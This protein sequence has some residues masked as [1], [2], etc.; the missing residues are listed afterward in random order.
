M[1]A[2]HRGESVLNSL[3][4]Y[5][6]N[7][8]GRNGSRLPISVQMV[9]EVDSEFGG[10]P[11]G[12]AKYSADE[13]HWMGYIYRYWCGLT[14]ETSKAVYKTVPARELR[15]FYPAYHTLDPEQ[16]VERIREAKGRPGTEVDEIRR[17]VEHLKALR[18]CI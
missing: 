12:S 16:A 9:E 6:R 15:S 17:G 13:L 1:P 2:C 4:T 8:L 10:K 18:A 3:R 5:D 14:G 7:K 11:Y